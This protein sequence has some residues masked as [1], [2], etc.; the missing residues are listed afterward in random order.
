M[1][2]SHVDAAGPGAGLD[3]PPATVPEALERHERLLA[4]GAPATDLCRV[5][6]PAVSFGIGVARDA[7]YLGRARAE[8]IEAVARGGGGSGLLHLDGDW[9]W[10]IVLPRSDPRVGRDYARA[11]ARLGTAVVRALGA[12]GVD[13][14][15]GDPPAAAEAYCTLSSRGQVLRVGSRILGGAAQHLTGRALLHHGTVSWSVDRPTIGRL[16]DLG[17]SSAVAELAGVGEL[18]PALDPSAVGARLARALR[19]ERER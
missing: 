7:P 10:A 6:R 11:Y 1:P 5:S 14:R 16:F 9:L 3:A 18:R 19:A 13:A 2:G 8:G 12:V 15:W 4:D 17:Q